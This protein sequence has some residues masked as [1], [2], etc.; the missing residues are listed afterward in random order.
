METPTERA[1]AVTWKGESP[2]IVAAL[3][4]RLGDIG[5]AEE[6]A[7]DALLAA[8]EQWPRSGIPDNPGAW[9]MAAA[10]HR[11]I[12]HFRRGKLL[13]RKHEE[14][15]RELELEERAVPS[16]EDAIDDDIGD[17]LTRLIF[18]ACHPMLSTESRV[19][20]TLRLLG[21]LSTVEI[22]RAFLVPEPTMAQRLVRAKRTLADAGVPFEVP[23]GPDREAR[24]ASVL[25]VI[26]LIFNEGHTAT[27]GSDLSR[28]EL[29][30]EAL[31]L[32]RILSELTPDEPEVLGLLALMELNESRASA[33]T[34]GA[35]DPVLLLV[36]DRSL[37]DRAAIERG[38]AALARAEARPEAPGPYRLQAA[39]HACHARAV[40]ADMTDWRRISELY[41]LLLALTRSP[42][43][44]LNRA[45]AVG[46]A[47]GAAAGLALLDALDGEPT[48]A[49]YHLLPAARADLLAK[50]DRAEEA[51][52]EFERA[53]SLTTNE[54]QRERLLA[55]ARALN[56][57]AS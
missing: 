53:A 8:L 47:D 26:Y 38:L 11:A 19:A 25:E 23:R 3:A 22:A 43:V 20:L 15:G 55:R 30:E 51:R 44:A 2:R 24:L 46:M 32:G 42:V 4:R 21:G 28:P 12:N 13:E 36:Q 27:E 29:S 14:L 35:G 48:L 1:I 49:R 17:D 9:L 37:W 57:R 10:K 40:T 50:L 5:L 52:S 6:V 31:R 39:I 33:R 7:Q 56:P 41:E 34:D 16:L 45:V 54:R 18:T